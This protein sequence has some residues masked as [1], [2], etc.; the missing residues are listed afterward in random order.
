MKDAF[1]RAVRSIRISATKRC[2]LNCFYC[3]MEGLKEAARDEMTPEELGRIGKIA[4]SIGIKRAKITG[5]EPL[6]RGDICEVIS[7]LRRSMGEISLTTNGILLP[8]LARKL[9][10]AGLDRVNVSIDTLEPE[11]YK[12]ITGMDELPRVIKGIKS[13][14]SEG[15]LPLKLN[16]VVMRGLNEGEVDGMIDFGKKTGAVV[17]LIELEADRKGTN[18]AFYRRYHFDMEGLETGLAKKAVRIEK[19]KM[20]HRMKYFVPNEVEMVRPMHNTEFCAHCSRI[21]LTSDGK[22]KPCLFES[23]KLVDILTPIRDGVTDR[24]LKELFGLAI[25]SRVPYWK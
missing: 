22:L 12:K 1:G 24:R 2:N 15:L 4:A 11:K 8:S 25:S 14:V 5:G 16:M 10:R 3:H 23:R 17:Q 18:R 20:Q 19:R 9:A 6:L 7:S 13:A 21:R